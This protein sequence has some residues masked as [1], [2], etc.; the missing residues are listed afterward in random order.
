[1]SLGDR[2]S[3]IHKDKGYSRGAGKYRDGKMILGQGKAG[4]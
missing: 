4:L 2:T 3:K 1:M